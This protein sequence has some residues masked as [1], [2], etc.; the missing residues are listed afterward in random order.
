VA[1][2]GLHDSTDDEIWNFAIA[3]DLIL[4]TKHEDFPSHVWIDRASPGIIWVTIGNCSNR[5]LIAVFEQ[6][7]SAIERIFAAKKNL[8]SNSKALE[9]EAQESQTSAAVSS[10]AD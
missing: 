5:A 9:Q 1:E 2:V 3:H 4:V 6:N 10:S 7:L 8:D